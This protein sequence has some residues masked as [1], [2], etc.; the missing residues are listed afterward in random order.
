MS[1]VKPPRAPMPWTLPAVAH[2]S[3]SAGR[4][5]IKPGREYSSISSAAAGAPKL[6]SIWK[7]ARLPK[8]Y[9]SKKLIAVPLLWFTDGLSTVR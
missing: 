8:L 7:V 3:G 4:S 1:T 9:M 5:S 2:A 6:A